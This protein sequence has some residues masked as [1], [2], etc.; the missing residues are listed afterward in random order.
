MFMK[1]VF[2]VFVMIVIAMPDIM[3]DCVGIPS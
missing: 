3:L 2:V 1:L